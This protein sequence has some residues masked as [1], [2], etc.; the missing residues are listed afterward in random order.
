MPHAEV[1]HDEDH[2]L[3]KLIRKA[4]RLHEEG[5]DPEAQA[6]YLDVWR[7]ADERGDDYHACL[8][9]HGLGVLEPSSMDEKLRW[10]V[11][12]LE[13]ANRVRDGRRTAGFYPSLYRES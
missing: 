3:M 7:Q 11:E 9:A 5:R 13:R 2:D 4:G 1:M 12:S 6:V 10:H 8:A